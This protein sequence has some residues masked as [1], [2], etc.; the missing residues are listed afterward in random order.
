MS[1]THFFPQI[2]L[3]GLTFQSNPR[4]HDLRPV[5]PSA[6][7]FI[8]RF[9][10]T[11]LGVIMDHRA[12]EEQLSS[13]VSFFEELKVFESPHS[14]HHA[15]IQFQSNQDSKLIRVLQILK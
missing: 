1:D 5:F 6:D 12:G 2:R 11:V 14:I 10:A 15:L 4:H 3:F 9:Q 13:D 7:Y 8:Y